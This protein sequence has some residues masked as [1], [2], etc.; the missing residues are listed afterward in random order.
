MLPTTDPG[1]N[2]EPPAGTRRFRP[3]R[4]GFL[5]GAG[6]GL[7]LLVGYALWPRQWPNAWVA[8][9]GEMLLG[10]WIKIGT[11]GRVT[12]AVPQAEMGQGVLS[13]FAQIVA[14]EL[15][16]TWGM[17]AV[18]PAPWHP[19]FAHVGMAR[20]GTAGLPPPIRGLAERLGVEAIRRLN[21]HLTGGS[22]SIMGYHDLLRE[23]AAEA[24]ARLAMAAAKEWGVSASQLDTLNGFV[25]YKANRMAFADAAQLVDPDREPPRPK[26]RPAADRRLDGRALPRLDLPP[27]V[28]GRARFGADV[29][30][31]GM[32][33]AAIRHGPIGGRLASAEAPAGVKLVKG[34]NWVAATGVTS[35]EAAR[36]LAQV[37]AEFDAPEGEGPTGEAGPWIQEALNAAI[38]G[39]EGKPLTSRGDVD[40]ALGETP[41]EASYSLPFL[42][43]ACLEPM[44]ATARVTDGA[45]EVWGP[46]QSLTLAHW[47][48]ADA[49]G[50]E[51]K[52]VLIHPTLL[53]GGFGRKAE[54]D[55]MV[56]AAL[57]ARAVGKPVQLLWSREEDLS[58]GSF[59][60][61]VA[62]W[63]RGQLTADRKGIAAWDAQIAVPSVG[64]SFMGRTLPR[65]AGDGTKPSAADIEGAAEI[66]YAAGAFRVTHLPVPQPVPLGY[67]RSVGHSFSAFLVESFV[68]E[69]AARAAI[70]PLAFRLG[71]L[72]DKPRHRAVLEAAADIGNWGQAQPKG[73]GRGI[74]LHESFGSIVAMVIEAGV[75]GGQIVIP[76]VAVAIDCGRA[77]A[78]DSVRAQLEGAAIMGLSAALGEAQTFEGGEAQA[79]NFDRYEILR[80]AGAPH[81]LV[82]VILPSDG[83][84]GGVGEP[85]LPPAAPALAN[86]LAAA[87]GTRARA[88]PLA[89]QYAG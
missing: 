59:R 15:G 88:L 51:S 6:A 61:P 14:D 73:F 36:A 11:D 34:P 79:R 89:R 16:A 70:D 20:L 69:L 26:L 65:F 48:V 41:V 10:P 4:R 7:G 9:E 87:T 66:P 13:G 60:P 3:T 30:L 44:T 76:K 23:A 85:G 25:V 74:A 38:A 81:S 49:L 17:M 35:F 71:L 63:F 80:M 22:T 8:G 40:A 46:T 62:A 39:T 54:P 2:A 83:P 21:L 72:P 5:I 58:A 78:P 42:A 64:A 82:T 28:D 75:V 19:A 53:G 12:V 27:K 37:K 57:I 32:V 18:E 45:A 67:W 1:P 31:P 24:R 29:R 77:I 47:R 68:D 33:F 43:H 56:E 86:A 50:L 84:L 55:A 52:D